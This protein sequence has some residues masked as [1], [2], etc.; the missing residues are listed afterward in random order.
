MA[1][2]TSNAL[3]SQNAQTEPEETAPMETSRRLTREALDDVDA[4]RVIAHQTVIDWAEKMLADALTQ[5]C[6]EAKDTETP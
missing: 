2:P 6:C 1:H 4:G 5:S 3:A